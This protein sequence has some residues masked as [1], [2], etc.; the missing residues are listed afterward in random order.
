MKL[1]PILEGDS[2]NAGLRLRG[3]SFP[4]I[5]NTAATILVV[6]GMLITSGCVGVT[7]KPGVSGATGLSI[8]VSPSTVSFG[9]L[10][11]G[12][13]ASQSLT[14]TNTG[15]KSL[16]VSGVSIAGSGFT[17]KA[18]SVPMALAAG[19]TAA[20]AATFTAAASGPASGKIMISSNAPNSPMIVAL[21]ATGVAKVSDLTASPA[22]LSFGTVTVGSQSAQALSLTN[23]GSS[24]MTISRVSASG[25]GI[26]V[27]GL[28]LP[29][30]LA[31]GAS[32]SLSAI[33]KPTAAGNASGTLTVTSNATNATD[34]IG[35]SAT[36]TAS[37]TTQLTANPSSVNFG[38]VATGSSGSTAIQLKNTGTASV[39][40]S[41]IATSGSGFTLSSLSLPLTL[42]PNQA[43][44]LTAGFKPTA[45]GEFS[46][47]ITVTS[48]ATDSPTAISLVGTAGTS[49]LTATPASVSFGTVPT[50]AAT[51]QTIRLTNSGDSQLTISGVSATGTGISVSGI[52]APVNIAA[53]QSAN[54]TASL[55]LTSA[56]AVSGAIK[57]ASNAAGSPTQIAWSA[58]GQ[59][60]VVT[61]TSSLASLSFGNVN[62]GTTDTLQT[63]IKNTGNSNANIS[64]ISVSGT[65]FSLSG[66]SSS[67]TLNPGQSV[68][69]SVSFDP[70]TAASD[71]GTMTIASNAT[72]S[73]FG[74]PLSG[75]GVN[76]PASSTQHSVALQW[77][78]SSSSVVGYY[79]YRSS[80]PSG[81]YARLNSSTTGGTSYSDG[82]VADGQVYYYVVT[83]VNS[84]NIESTDSNQVSATIPSN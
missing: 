64:K 11:V 30:T 48:S 51:T 40:I 45:S 42:A 70:K 50:G 21:T 55:K 24:S 38:T 59:A 14:I 16:T 27:S 3:V 53:G 8:Q 44:T 66:S 72:V 63:V 37:S 6:V 83:A 36:A 1:T 25:A 60:S 26:S 68:T 35:W 76:K 22:S 79:I 31:A 84:S 2:V 62:V 7:G 56:G 17:L 18:I 52:T 9:S 46:E 54:L 34:A 75:T 67:A 49:G 74:V 32:A 29:V 73:Q 58:T 81:P 80:K 69:L 65:G 41:S 10:T 57:I 20:V 5:L 13:S 19:Q 47:H 71:T 82:T 39:K 23:S 4:T 12:Q 15:T 77:D 61:L 28:S 78:A 33:F 43:A